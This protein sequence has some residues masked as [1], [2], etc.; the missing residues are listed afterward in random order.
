MNLRFHGE[1]P[2]PQHL[3]L[4]LLAPLHVRPGA[5]FSSYAMRSADA[6]DNDKGILRQLWKFERAAEREIGA[7]KKLEATK[8]VAG[9]KE[10]PCS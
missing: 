7:L 3:A 10:G 6:F 9:E 4:R 2:D 5:Q 1:R 8:G